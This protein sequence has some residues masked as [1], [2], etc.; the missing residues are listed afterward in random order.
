MNSKNFLCLFFQPADFLNNYDQLSY[1][2]YF[3]GLPKILII[4]SSLNQSIHFDC[5][6]LVVAV[7]DATVDFARQTRW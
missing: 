6:T 2:F 7:V 3:L 5:K 1:R 4:G